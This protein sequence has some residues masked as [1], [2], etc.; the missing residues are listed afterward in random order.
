MKADGLQKCVENGSPTKVGVKLK[1]KGSEHVGKPVRN[2]NE[3][4]GRR[5]MPKTA[6][7]EKKK[8]GRLPRKGGKKS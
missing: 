7:V 1:E 8:R 4:K 6:L 2:Q 3:S 5:R